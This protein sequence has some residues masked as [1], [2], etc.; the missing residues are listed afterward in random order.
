M[1]AVGFPYSDF[2]ILPSA[3]LPSGVAVDRALWL[4]LRLQARGWVRSLGRNLRSVK[5]AL[6]ALLAVV[7]FIPWLM[8]ILTQR[9]HSLP[10]D[11]LRTNGPAYLLGYC[12]LNVLISSGERAVY[13]SPAEV[14][15]L[16]TGPFT[17]RQLLG[18]KV[19]LTLLFTLPTTL[20]MTA[21]FRVHAPWLLAAIVGMLLITTFMQMFGMALSLAASAVGARLFTRARMLVVAVG[22]VGTAL[23]VQSS[24]GRGI[25][26]L[27]HSPGWH[28]ATLPLSWFFEAFLANNLIDLMRFGALAL[29]V[30]LALLAV[31]FGLD[32]DYLEAAAAYS[33]RVYS[34]IQR[35]RGGP[36]ISGGGDGPAPAVKAR[37]TWPMLPRFGGIG[38]L[39]WRQL[40]TAVRSP[41]RLIGLVAIQAVMT[42]V[43]LGAAGETGG[44]VASPMALA[45]AV[46][47]LSLFVSSVLPF[48]FRG[49][50]DRLETLKTW[51]LAPWRLAVGQMLPPAL[52]LSAFQWLMLAGLAV[53]AGV[54]TG[55]S[56]VERY[57]DLVVLGGCAA[58]ALPF[59]FLLIGLEN[60]LFLLAPSR[61]MAGTAGDFQSIGRNVLM[62]LV[63][64]V[65]LALIGVTAGLAV[66]M[67]QVTSGN[68]LLLM[69][70]AAWVVLTDSAAIL[71][72]VAGLLFTWVDVNRD[73]P[74]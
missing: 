47:V 30:N 61:Q 57:V 69:S 25:D 51:P 1:N 36:A 66:F 52:V 58:I 33:T 6:L 32:A 4:L 18:Y 10:A 41:G 15:F 24:Q 40:V 2:C 21:V 62:M 67:V 28:A 72:P 9:S 23:L 55:G 26:G 14:T 42:S 70:A 46:V 39:V 13:F 49:D 27:L 65:A 53:Y 54:G 63:K 43:L 34:Q 3:F 37:R 56:A 64:F 44:R 74:A 71:V 31:V 8:I 5:G 16:F 17:R 11:Q 38:P 19:A 60:V 29:L 50:L 68:N 48:D 73:K 20:F 12:I 45:V 22:L 35:I 59:N 7:V